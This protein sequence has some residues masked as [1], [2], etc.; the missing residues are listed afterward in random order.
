MVNYRIPKTLIMKDF[1]LKRLVAQTFPINTLYYQE[2]VVVVDTVDPLTPEQLQ[3]L[4]E[5]V[6]NFQDPAVFLEL[7]STI[8]DVTTSKTTNSQTPENIKTF[9]YASKN[10]TGDATFN[11]L[12]T[13]VDYSCTSTQPFIDVDTSVPITSTIQIFCQTRNV[14]LESHTIDITDIVLDWKN[15]AQNGDLS[16]QTVYRTFMIEGMRVKVANYDCV[17]HVKAAVSDANISLTLHG[18]QFLYYDVM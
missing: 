11:A 14:L 16:A 8:T 2:P 18:M 4:Q 9:I 13:V 5:I 12:K 10:Q 7:N 17:W 1:A 15:K 3:Q 6:E